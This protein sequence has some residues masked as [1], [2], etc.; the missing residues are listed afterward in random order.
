MSGWKVSPIKK[1]KEEKWLHAT[2]N[3]WVLFL[4]NIVFV[5]SEVN[6]IAICLWKNRV[7]I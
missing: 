2:S 5:H 6:N 7:G 1:S 3:K 4:H